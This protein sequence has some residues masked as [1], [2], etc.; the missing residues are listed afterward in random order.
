MKD[1]ERRD[2]I[3]DRLRATR[4]ALGLSQAELCQMAEIAPNTYNQWEKG[5]QG[6]SVV[7][8]IKL[9]NTFHLSL[10]WIFRGD[11][12]TLPFDLATKLTGKYRASA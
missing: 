12:S 7:G 8:A 9:C 3:A 11:I 10:D 6:I 4:C 2:A 5:R 1:A